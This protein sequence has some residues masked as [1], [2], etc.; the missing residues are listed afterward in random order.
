VANAQDL[1]VSSLEQGTDPNWGLSD[2]GK[3]QADQCGEELLEKLGTFNPGKLVIASSP[4]SRCIETA[5]RVGSHFDIHLHDDE[6]FLRMENLRERFFGSYD[7]SK[8]MLS[9]NAVWKEDEK[10]AEWCP[11]DGG[12]SVTAVAQRVREA[13]QVLEERYAQEG[14]NIIIVSHGDALSIL[15]CVLRDDDLCQHRK[16]GTSNCEIVRF[17]QS[18]LED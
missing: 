14:Y 6:R 1:I 10:S 15:S 11:P 18:Q 5:A 17:P 12:E 9:Y 7:K 16:Y 3:I 8:S 4:F 2:I 13:V